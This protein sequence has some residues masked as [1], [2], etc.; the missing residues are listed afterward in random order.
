MQ[1][2][3]MMVVAAAVLG[4]LARQ[5][6]NLQSGLGTVGQIVNNA[7]EILGGS[8]GA[9]PGTVSANGNVPVLPAGYPGNPSP[10]G[11]TSN[12][13]GY[14]V[15]NYAGQ[16]SPGYPPAIGQQPP[17]Q[18]SGLFANETIRI[19]SFN[20]EVL[21]RAKLSNPDVSGILVD[22]VR[23][24]DVIAI[25]ELRSTEQ[26][27]IPWF[28]EQLNALQSSGQ[29]RHYQSIVGYRQGYTV[30]K[31]QY[32]FLYDADRI[33]TLGEAF[34]AEDPA[35]KIHRSPM[36]ARFQCLG[37]PPAEAF[38]FALMNVHTDPDVVP[39]E[40]GRL[41]EVIPMIQAHLPDEDDLILL[42]D[43]NCWP[44]FF[45]DYQ[46]LPNQ[47]GLIGDDLPT[48]T[49]KDRN[50]DNLVIDATR[51]TEWTGA[52]GVF[53]MERVY[54]L[55]RDQALQVSD[56]MPVWGQFYTREQRMA[57]AQIPQLQ[58]QFTGRG[59]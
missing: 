59:Q 29:R 56:H 12:P 15:P 31:E 10:S 16:P 33:G 9:L 14:Y 7:E 32:V 19:G 35:G 26:N 41:A 1:K 17:I 27:I 44:S 24:F 6:C 28:V 42:G 53:D 43:L 50:Y 3:I 58:S 30:S 55:T 45:N 18:P 54:G 20:I 49:R 47:R 38:T 21:G 39:Q 40:L 23:H 22:I 51:T 34:I 13:G 57:T 5:G 48:N 8:A 25:Q 46:M 4:L 2:K 37:L 11:P 36:V 52:A